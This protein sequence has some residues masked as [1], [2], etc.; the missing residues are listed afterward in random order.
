MEEPAGPSDGAGRREAAAPRQIMSGGQ[1]NWDVLTWYL[2]ISK[3]ALALAVIG[4]RPPGK[5]SREHAEHLARNLCHKEVNW[6]RK[7]EAWKAEVLH[8][9]QELLL[10]RMRSMPGLPSG[11]G[12]KSVSS[13][14]TPCQDSL[15]SKNDFCHL[16]DSGCDLTNGQGS[17]DTQDL[18]VN[19]G[20]GHLNAYLLTGKEAMVSPDATLISAGSNPAK[21][22]ESQEKEKMLRLHTQF[23]QSL[24]R[25]K[26]LTADRTLTA[27]SL[28]PGSDCSVV[29]DSVSQVAESLLAFC[30]KPRYPLSASL[31]MEVTQT[32]V[33]LMDDATLPK[34]VL[35]HC[36]KRV[37]E[38]M[39][40][41]IK[42][43][44]V[45][46]EVNRNQT[47]FDVSAYENIYYLFWVFEQLLQHKKPEESGVSIIDCAEQKHFQ[48]RLDKTI[49]HLAD[50]FP[51]F[52]VYM[53]RLGVLL[54]TPSQS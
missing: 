51:L 13:L 2:K 6:K 32:L 27:A 11:I 36:M 21:K 42:V 18:L 23:L 4:R 22:E 54:N 31:L 48:Q 34:M 44:L 20:L 19:H 14:E 35:A 8:L 50:D 29:T 26:K 53:W 40:K 12:D 3:L 45:N 52:A 49:L 43:L 17:A 5:S 10:S 7:A 30:Q 33:C 25:I 41:F 39:K 24:I 15:I 38:L 9:R 37:E 1:P 46:S 16:E 28:L 47:G